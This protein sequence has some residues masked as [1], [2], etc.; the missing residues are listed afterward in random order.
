MLKQ[1]VAESWCDTYLK[2]GHSPLSKVN[3]SAVK[4]HIFHYLLCGNVW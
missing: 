2:R 1:G 4:L 3:L